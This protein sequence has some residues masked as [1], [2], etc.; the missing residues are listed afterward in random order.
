MALTQSCHVTEGF[1]MVL[2]QLLRIFTARDQSRPSAD[3]PRGCVNEF[4][5][6]AYTTYTSCNPLDCYFVSYVTV[7]LVVCFG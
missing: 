5:Q 4:L 1:G 7:H 6:A 3:P 2:L